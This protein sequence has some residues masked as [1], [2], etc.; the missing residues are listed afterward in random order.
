[1]NLTGKH[2][3]AIRPSLSVMPASNAG[4]FFNSGYAFST[5]E[6]RIQSFQDNWPHTFASPS[7]HDVLRS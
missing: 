1:M 5:Y 4:G 7:S 2:P 3:A 6:R